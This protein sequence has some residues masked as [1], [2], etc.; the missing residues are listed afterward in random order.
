MIRPRFVL[1]ILASAAL[2]AAPA[3]A[4]AASE[5]EE[6]EA[7]TEPAETEPA[8]STAPAEETPEEPAAEETEAV[9]RPVGDPMIVDAVYAVVDTRVITVSE[10]ARKVEPMVQRYLE[11]NP[12]LT[13]AEQFECRRQFFGKIAADM[14]VR[15][16]IL[17]AARDEGLVVDE[18][19]VGSQIRRLLVSEGMTL[20]EYL[21][22]HDLTYQELFREVH[23]DYLFS[24]YR[25]AKIVPRVYVSPGEVAAYYD[26]FKDD[27]EFLT[28]GQ[29]RCHEIVLFGHDEERQ[30]KAAE[31]LEKLAA[32]AE[33]AEVARE[34]SEIESTARAGGDRGWI[35][36]SVI[37]SERVNAA[38]F[39]QLEV[40]EVSEVI[41][42]EKGFLWIVMI[43]GRR[44]A[45]R[46]PLSQAY[47]KIERRLRRIKIEEETYRHADRLKKTTAV[48]SGLGF[49]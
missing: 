41:E 16:L 8:E 21:D 26:V 33:F 5:P 45:V 7:A 15:E 6:P 28:P 17:K 39:D 36:R 49:N 19:R 27:P 35:S 44:D 29:V 13:E 46:T 43:T 3:G 9:T 38:L 34:Y 48:I 47:E 25:L 11:S 23:D 14:I 18:A 32:G 2:L 20:E 4:A 31:A 10:I 30:Q 1:L 42:D 24:V 40:G 22:K 12:S 37:N